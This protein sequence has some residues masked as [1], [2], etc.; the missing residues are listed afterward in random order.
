MRLQLSS[1]SSELKKRWES[2]A[3]TMIHS[4]RIE[5]IRHLRT[6]GFLDKEPFQNALQSCNIMQLNTINAYLTKE[7]SDS[8][9]REPQLVERIMKLVEPTFSFLG[10]DF[11]WTWTPSSTEGLNSQQI[12]SRINEGS[13]HCLSHLQFEECWRCAQGYTEP[14]VDQVVNQHKFI[15]DG[16]RGYLQQHPSWRTRFLEVEEVSHPVS[17][18]T[19]LLTPADP[20][21]WEPISSSSRTLWAGSYYSKGLLRR[22]SL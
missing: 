6:Y 2:E 22:P 19:L 5:H 1:E 10:L 8:G 17:T 13:Y 3:M 14:I 4:G 9:L 18:F 15:A 12:A 20:P 7:A 16:I 21:V 11:S